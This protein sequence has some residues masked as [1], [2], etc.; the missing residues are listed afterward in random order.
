MTLKKSELDRANG[1]IETLASYNQTLEKE[2]GEMR[3]KVSVLNEQIH[4]G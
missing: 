3:N 1:K 2:I 4:S